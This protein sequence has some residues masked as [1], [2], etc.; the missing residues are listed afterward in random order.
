LP[1]KN[2]RLEGWPDA[3]SLKKVQRILL[4]RLIVEKRKKVLPLQRD[5]PF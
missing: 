5:Y 2:G 1:K 4:G 3:N